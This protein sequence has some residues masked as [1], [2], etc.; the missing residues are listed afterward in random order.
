MKAKVK[1]I[2]TEVAKHPGVA[3]TVRVVEVAGVQYLDIRDIVSSPGE[4]VAGRG[5]LFPISDMPETRAE[6][7]FAIGESL[8]AL[9]SEVEQ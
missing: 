7:L 6:Q 9:A 5:Y 2:L 3:T 4:V 8:C 1:K